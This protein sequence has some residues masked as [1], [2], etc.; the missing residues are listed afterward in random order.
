MADVLVA[1]EVQKTVGQLFTKLKDKT[2]III[3]VMLYT[4]LLIVQKLVVVKSFV[5]LNLE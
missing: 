2:D 1:N 5:T 4:N 3:Y